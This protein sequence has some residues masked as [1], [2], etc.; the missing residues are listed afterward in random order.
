MN[1]RVL[2]IEND[3]DIRLIVDYIL[4]EQGFETLSI[5]EPEE[6]SDILNFRADVILLDEFVNSQ[7]GH[8]L[9]RKIK[10]IPK[11]AAIPVIILSTANDIE[12]IVKE[13]NAND[14]IS[15]PF[16]I[17]LMVDK[18]LRIVNHQPLPS[19]ALGE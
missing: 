8:R 19:G 9:C 15:K 4:Q 2:I 6:L 12:L 16:D 1:K 5:P 11:L 13:C 14:Y 18:V 3:Q 10:N 17:E 7:P